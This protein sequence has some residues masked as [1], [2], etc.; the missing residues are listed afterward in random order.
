MGRAS[1]ATCSAEEEEEE[2]EEEE[3]KLVIITR[4]SLN[5]NL[6]LLY[7]NEFLIDTL[8]G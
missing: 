6:D 2:E 5:Y 4:Q 8:T 3:G 7:D 1:V